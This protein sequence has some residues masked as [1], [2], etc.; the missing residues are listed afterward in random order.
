MRAS[1]LLAPLAA[2]AALTILP[3]VADAGCGCMPIG[4]VSAMEMRTP[5]DDGGLDRLGSAVGAS[6]MMLNPGDDAPIGFEL[7]TMFLRGDQGERLYDLGLSVLVTY[8][9]RDEIAAPMAEFGLDLAASSV[10]NAAGG[11]DRGVT[12]GVHG[13]VGI[14]GMVGDN[15]YWRGLVGYHG[16]GIGGVVGQLSLGYRFGK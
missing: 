10:P 9:F 1:L 16:A 8:D 5:S 11:K 13:G 12:A 6:I 7:G 4:A 14:H 3:R 2:A 15:L